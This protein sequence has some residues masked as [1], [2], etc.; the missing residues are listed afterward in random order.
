MLVF[1]ERGFLVEGP[2][3][4]C[5][6]KSLAHAYCPLVNTMSLHCNR[7]L[8]RLHDLVSSEHDRCTYVHTHMLSDPV[9]NQHPVQ[10][11]TVTMFH[12]ITHVPQS[13]KAP[14]LKC[15]K[16]LTF[17][18]LP[19]L[20]QVMGHSGE[21]AITCTLWPLDVHMIHIVINYKLTLLTPMVLP[22]QKHNCCNLHNTGCYQYV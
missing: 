5:Y 20:P 8:H 11:L 13:A 15:Q 9:H 21:L 16:S 17:W 14:E 22:I 12:N 19:E 10:T 6:C 18:Q 3:S 7:T 1:Q 2:N 4:S